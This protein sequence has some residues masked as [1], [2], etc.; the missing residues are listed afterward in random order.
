[1]SFSYDAK[2]FA[3]ID[4][5]LY[6]PGAFCMLIMFLLPL[7]ISDT[8]PAVQD[9]FYSQQNVILPQQQNHKDNHKN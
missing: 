7:L 6:L 5:F 2:S 4:W 3:Q 8:T 9:L 1:M